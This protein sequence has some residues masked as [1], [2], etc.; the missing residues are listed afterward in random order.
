MR[1]SLTKREADMLLDAAN[2]MLCD[3][4]WDTEEEGGMYKEDDSTILD[5]AADKLGVALSKLKGSTP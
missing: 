1:I 5:K 2:R 3:D 4:V